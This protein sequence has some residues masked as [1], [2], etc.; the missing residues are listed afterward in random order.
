M[1][2][3]SISDPDSD[4]KDHRDVFPFLQLPGEIRN[5]IYGF[6]LPLEIPEDIGGIS[7]LSPGKSFKSLMATCHRTLLTPNPTLHP[8]DNRPEIFTEMT[9]LRFSTRTIRFRPTKT[10]LRW[11]HHGPS[12]RVRRLSLT[13]PLDPPT[14]TTTT[15]GSNPVPPSPSSSF[16]STLSM[17]TTLTQAMPLLEDLTLDTTRTRRNSVLYHTRYAAVTTGSWADSCVEL[18]TIDQLPALLPRLI[19]GPDR[20]GMRRL[21]EEALACPGGRWMFVQRAR[22]MALFAALAAWEGEKRF[23]GEELVGVL[24]GWRYLR[25][26]RVV[27]R[28]D[29][30]WMEVVARRAVVTVHAREKRRGS[31]RIRNMIYEYLAYNP[32]NPTLRDIVVD[33][34][35]HQVGEEHYHY[36]NS[37][38]WLRDALSLMKTCHQMHQEVPSYLYAS[39]NLRIESTTGV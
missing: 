8:F 39:V 19:P 20:A 16:R 4:M 12:H 34:F 27:G 29:R 9:Y 22:W 32:M 37:L 28:V 10:H 13:L 25:D 23:Y 6:L 1:H 31:G 11:L 21:I 7:D 15:I 24:R 26:V 3:I 33:P 30:E 2:E 36:N 18:S 5:H 14:T 38:R 17:L 35:T